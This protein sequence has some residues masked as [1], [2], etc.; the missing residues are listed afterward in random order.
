MKKVLL[1]LLLIFTVFAIVNFDD[2]EAKRWNERY[3]SNYE[4]QDGDRVCR[5]CRG[6]GQ[7]R[8]CD[9]WGYIQNS[10]GND[11][12]CWECDTSGECRYCDGKGYY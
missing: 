12:Q 10:D 5:Y 6:S 2:A 9:G 3:E 7:C 8:E 11:E 1:F 4:Y